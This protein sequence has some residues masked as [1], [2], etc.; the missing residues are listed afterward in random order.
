VIRHGPHRNRKIKHRDAQTARWSHNP[1]LVFKINK[2][3]QHICKKDIANHNL[4]EK[5]SWDDPEQDGVDRH[6]K[7][8]R[9]EEVTGKIS[10]RY[11][12]GKKEEIAHFS[13]APGGRNFCG[14]DFKNWE[15]QWFSNSCSW[16]PIT[17]YQRHNSQI[18]KH[19]SKGLKNRIDKFHRHRSFADEINVR[20]NTVTALR[21]AKQREQ[22]SSPSSG[23]VCSTGSRLADTA[24]HQSPTVPAKGV[25]RS[26]RK[27]QHSPPCSA[28]V[29]N[30]WRY[31]YISSYHVMVL[32]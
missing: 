2:L 30:P 3:R 9:R 25:K 28:E 12:C 4:K 10:K 20:F 16:N 1:L 15:V 24:S 29:T 8:S 17:A 11:G 23:R 13:S 32:N 18:N 5:I 14:T 6:W 31:T 21:P 7:I 19:R 27:A 22:G 26:V